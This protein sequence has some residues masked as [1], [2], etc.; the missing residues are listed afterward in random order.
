ML[1]LSLGSL[2]PFRP[3]VTG[4]PNA[5]ASTHTRTHAQRT[6]S[7]CVG[8]HA[9]VPT[10]AR[11]RSRCSGRSHFAS[12]QPSQDFKAA[13]CTRP[14]PTPPPTHTHWHCACYQIP[15]VSRT[16]PMHGRAHTTCMGAHTVHRTAGV[17]VGQR[18]STV[19]ISC[20][21][22]ARSV[23]RAA[24]PHGPRFKLFTPSGS[25]SHAHSRSIRG[26]VPCAIDPCAGHS[27][28]DHRCVRPA[29]AKL[30]GPAL[31]GRSAAVAGDGEREV[32][33]SP[34]CQHRRRHR[35]RH[36]VPVPL[37]FPAT[38]LPIPR[39]ALPAHPIPHLPTPTTR[40]PRSP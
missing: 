11:T 20:R 34:D 18:V 30:A 32:R 9:P 5:R 16:H 35:L 2:R 7:T 8:T 24:A 40:S 38:P 26:S 3:F 12:V 29:R 25:A 14:S 4:P 15:H 10:H 21:S 27:L 23:S 39:S 6:S 1:P 28:Y 36:A 33:P 19:A 31:F 13:V 37:S 22:R 17:N